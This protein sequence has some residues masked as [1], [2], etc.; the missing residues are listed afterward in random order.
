M[1]KFIKF[2]EKRGIIINKQILEDL[3]KNNLFYPMFRIKLSY[4]KDLDQYAHP[5]SDIVSF[6]EVSHNHNKVF[7]PNEEN[8][9][10][11]IEYYD[12][13]REEYNVYT[14]YS[15]YQIY[16]LDLLINKRFKQVPESSNKLIDLLIAIQVYSPYGRSN[17]R[18]IT[19][20]GN[21]YNWKLHLNKLDMNE[22]FKI[23][24]IDEDFLFKSYRF[25]CRNLKPLLGSNDAIQLWKHVRW[26]R[27]KKCIGSTRLGIEYLEWAMM[28]KRCIEHYIGR[29][30]YDVD[31]ISN[32]SL[33]KIK[34]IPSKDN[35]QTVRGV[36]NRDFYNGINETYEFNLNRK[37][38]FYLSNSLTLDYHPRI[39]LFVEGKTEEELIPEFYN[40]FYGDFE[41]AGFEIINIGGIS[42][43]FSGELADRQPSGKYMKLIV[44]NFT[45]LINFNL[46]TWQAIPFFVADNENNILENLQKGKIINL[47]DAFYLIHGFSVNEY[48]EI[49]KYLLI[50]FMDFLNEF[51]TSVNRENS[52]LEE[53]LSD[54]FNM[55][56]NLNS[57]F[58]NEWSY[59]WDLDFE[60]DNYEPEELQKAILEVFNKK[61]PLNKI[62][63]VYHPSEDGKKQ[64]ISDLDDD[65]GKNKIA[66]NRKLLGNLVKE[67]D[68]TGDPEILK[69]PIFDLI[70]NLNELKYRYNPAKN[71][72]QL[73]DNQ[74]EIYSKILYG[75]QQN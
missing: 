72:M 63:D 39:L 24:N 8:F 41:D 62:K 20:K 53:F 33:D 5:A 58:I 16:Q 68:E 13:K 32:Y 43:F 31:E 6:L 36:R 10:P 22:I 46:K 47:K 60:L 17:M 2:C 56:K 59:I 37:H 12:K 23:L 49:F 15:S 7:L 29:E 40:E 67:Y 11:F 50:E 52:F 75:Q 1:D 28:L 25:I 69:R 38:L 27:K 9:K 30:I 54:N 18:L 65:I 70:M 4:Q 73:I 14:Y 51:E 71:T 3:E 48:D 26:D 61:I 55:S 45:N 34:T 74:R 21:D 64:G 19:V 35:G 44:S 42:S 66:L 57:T